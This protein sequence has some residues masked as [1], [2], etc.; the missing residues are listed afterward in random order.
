MA[1]LVGSAVDIAREGQDVFATAPPRRA[2][3]SA[4]L[5]VAQDLVAGGK[6]PL[7]ARRERT[8]EGWRRIVLGAGAHLDANLDRPIYTEDL[9]RALAVSPAVLAE[10]FQVTLGTS[11]HRHLKLRRLNMVRAAL[12]RRDGPPPL[13]KSVALS[14]GFWHLGQ[15]ARDYREQFGESPSET[16]AR[17]HGQAAADADADADAEPQPVARAR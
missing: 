16:L 5:G 14:H 8:I 15:F 7:A 10:A 12:M 4:L 6:E 2:F 1:K 3:R 11:P 17:A 9:C 13:V